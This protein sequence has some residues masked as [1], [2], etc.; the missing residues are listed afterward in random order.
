MGESFQ[1]IFGIT[2][3]CL[4]LLQREAK[5]ASPEANDDRPEQGP[6][7]PANEVLIRAVQKSHDECSAERKDLESNSAR[8]ERNCDVGAEAVLLKAHPR[9]RA[10]CCVAAC[11]VAPMLLLPLR[12]HA[13]LGQRGSIQ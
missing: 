10:I 3:F 1:H 2:N 11:L 4:F 8:S 7:R 12:E 9:F 6:E 13:S 5:G